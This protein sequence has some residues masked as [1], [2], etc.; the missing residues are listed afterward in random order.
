VKSLSV[1]LNWWLVDGATGY[2]LSRNGVS[3]AEVGPTVGTYVDYNAPLNVDLLYE[4]DARNAVGSTAPE[5]VMVPAC[6]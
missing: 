4:L 3:L 2:H 6:D 5:Y 1:T